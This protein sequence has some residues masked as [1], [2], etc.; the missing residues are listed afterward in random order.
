MPAITMQG[1]AELAH[2]QRPVVSM[3]R[4][5]FATADRPFP[6]PK[7]SDPPVFD[8]EEVGRWLQE[9]GH[10]NNAD[11]WLETSLHSKPLQGAATD[12]DVTS[13]LLLLHQLR[14]EPVSGV[15]PTDIHS[16][17]AALGLEAVLDDVALADALN[18]PDACKTVDELAEAAFSGGRVLDRIVDTFVA[19]DGPWAREALTSTAAKFLA[20]VVAEVYRAAPRT[21]V[22]CGPGGLLLANS[23]ANHLTEQDHACFGRR[24]DTFGR[25]CDRAAWRGIAANGFSIMPYDPAAETSQSAAA[26]FHLLMWQDVSDETDFFDGVEELL[27]NLSDWDALVVVGPA[28]LMT[29]RPGERLRHRLLAPTP[30]Y[31]AP[32]RYV[33]R[34]PKGLSR[35]GGRR[36]LALWVFGRPASTW[37]VVGSHSDI[38]M[39][40]EAATAIAAD[41]TAAISDAVDVNAHAF[42]SSAVVRSDR[43]L[44]Q[45]A[46]LTVPVNTAVPVDGGEQLARIWELDRGFLRGVELSA[47]PARPAYV[48]MSDAAPKLAHDLPGTRVPLKYIDKPETGSAIVIGPDETRNPAHIGRRGVDRIVLETVSPHARLTEPGDVVYVSAGGPAAIVD[49]EGGHVVQAPARIF[50]CLTI[51]GEARHLVPTVA[52]ADI[53]AQLGSDRST[54]QLRAVEPAQANAITEITRHVDTQCERL[55]DELRNLDALNAEL[56]N[57]LSAHSLTATISTTEQSKAEK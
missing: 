50:R 29:D 39:D 19:P 42:H 35:F 54:W 16:D 36:R 20:A 22:P 11:A 33:A 27:L 45:T 52:A 5:R 37:T 49:H 4:K 51:K 9:T 24:E 7:Q 30:S 44:R 25:P 56:I 12:L 38:A 2:V 48:S 34:L 31:T 40:A 15:D 28:R 46:S 55:R 43:Y 1:I 17:V 26:L 10:G 6:E 32:L 57:G 47:A 53:A 41:V 14:G 21:I 23:L 18:E 3:W 8:A 13:T